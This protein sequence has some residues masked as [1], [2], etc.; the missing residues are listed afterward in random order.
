MMAFHPDSNLLAQRKS[1]YISVHMYIYMGNLL[2]GLECF[3][4]VLKLYGKVE[5]GWVIVT[6]LSIKATENGKF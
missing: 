5:N 1:Q 2:L 6:S 3:P 4:G